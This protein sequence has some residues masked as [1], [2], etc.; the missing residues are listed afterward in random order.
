MKESIKVKT[1]EKIKLAVDV[2]QPEESARA[3]IVVVHGMAEH[4]GRYQELG[5]YLS[6]RGF[7]VYVYDQRGNGDSRIASLPLGMISYRQGWQL[8]KDDVAQMMSL[9]HSRHRGLPVFLIGHSMGSLLARCVVTE[10]GE[11]LSGLVLSGTAKNPGLM[12]YLGR[13]LAGLVGAFQG[14]KKQ[15]PFLDRL[16]FKDANQGVTDPQTPFDW[17]SRDEDKV[18]AYLDDPLAGFVAPASFYQELLRGL[19]EAWRP[20]TFQAT[21]NILPILLIGG[22]ADP[23]G[24]QGQALNEAASSYRRHGQKKVDVLLYE[25]GRHEMFNETNRQE[26]Y[27][28]LEDWINEVMVG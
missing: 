13:M 3:V 20:E 22:D 16:L 19:V 21:D 12:G 25:G 4:K 7:V 15:S 1:R 8:L 23:V 24:D 11:K 28:D 5:Q 2:Y 6:D 17:L 26:V 18:R 9:A 27:Q 14:K 10:S